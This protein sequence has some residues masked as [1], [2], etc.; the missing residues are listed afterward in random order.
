M[1]FQ[2]WNLLYFIFSSSGIII[3]SKEKQRLFL[4]SDTQITLPHPQKDLDVL[5]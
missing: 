5:M 2:H 1:A 3:C 4:M